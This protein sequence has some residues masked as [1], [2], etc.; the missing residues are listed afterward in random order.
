MLFEETSLISNDLGIKQID[1][2]AIEIRLIIN[3]NVS[4]NRN[5]GEYSLNAL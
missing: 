2:E 5:L 1:R 4:L 3:S